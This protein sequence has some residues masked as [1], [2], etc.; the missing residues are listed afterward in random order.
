MMHAPLPHVDDVWL[1]MHDHALALTQHQY[2]QAALQATRAIRDADAKHYQRLAAE[3]GHAYTHEGLTSIWKKIKAVLPKNRMKQRSAKFDIECELQQHFA[4]LEAGTEMPFEE[5][6]RQCILRN[7]RDQDACLTPSFIDLHELPTLAE[8]EDLCLKQRPLRAAGLDGIPPEVCRQAAVAIAPFLHNV[9]LKAFLD[10][11]E[12]FSYKGGL[13]CPIWKQKLPRHDASGYRGILLANVFGKVLHAWARSRLLPTLLARSAAGQIGGLPSQQTSTA[14]QLLR[15]HGKLGRARKLSTAALFVD[16]RAA[17]HHMLREFIF[18]VR[19]PATR[20]LL[21]RI[22]DANEFD[23]EQLSHDL[24]AECDRNPADIPV[25]LRAF[26]HDIHK[27]TWY[28]LDARSKTATATTR[29]TRPGSP[30]ADIGFN[31]LITKILHEVEEALQKIPDYVQ[32]CQALGVTIPPLAWVDDLAIPVAVLRPEAL[33]PVIQEITGILHSTFRSHGLTMNLE[34]GKTEAVLMYR[35]SGAP[36]HRA[37]LFA[38]ETPPVIVI[39]TETHISTL[40]VVAAYRHLGSQYTMN[41]DIEHEIL[42]RIA[43]ARQAFEELKRP[44]FLN[45]HIPI[46]GRLQ[47]YNSLI[48]SRLLYGCAVWSDIPAAQVRKL[49]AF[50]IDH[51]RRIA[52][53]GF[54]NGATM[55]DEDLRHHLE[56]PTFRVV[57]ARHRLIYLQHIARHGKDFH[58]QLLLLEFQLRR[59]WLWEALADLCW[60]RSLIDLPFAFEDDTIDWHAVWNAIAHCP[61]WKAMVQRA[62]RKHV[63]QERIARDVKHFHNLI[64]HEMRDNDAPIDESVIDEESPQAQ[65]LPCRECDRVFP[66]LQALGAHEYQKHGLTSLERPYIQSTVCPG[67]LKDFWTTWRVQQ[68]LRYRNNKCWDRIHG[69][70]QP[71]EPVTIG[72]PQHLRHVKR[73]P[74]VRRHHGPLLPTGDQRRRRQL[75]L[76]IDEL[77]AQGQD[78]FAWWHPEQDPH[79]AQ[80]ACATFNAVLVAWCALPDPDAIQFQNMFF[81]AIFSLEIPEL[82]GGRL[83]VHWIETEF[84]DQ[85]PQDL[86]PDAARCLEEAHMQMLDDIPAWTMRLQMKHLLSVWMHQMS[87]EEPVPTPSPL[88]TRPYQRRHFIASQYSAMGAEEQQ[89]GQ[90]KILQRFPLR[91]PS[92][93][94]PYYVVHLYS[95]RRRPQDFH[96]MVEELITNLLGRTVRI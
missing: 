88:T 49:E 70:R 81:G 15:L 37:A 94:G 73:L 11:T 2:R 62:C 95:G 67:C 46:E 25:A 19:E 31:L 54:W 38:R 23:I 83:F 44:I 27:N 10:G 52:D 41:A 55:T 43:T 21:Y 80:R 45:R 93:F 4:D 59:G 71:D 20:S 32:G 22:F 48:I 82:L 50:F 29:G 30:L 75:Q 91:E 17:F 33:I 96:A 86:D 36:A 16:L 18:A 89:R 64:V 53:I 66:T 65:H 78:E 68:H 35:G 85:W 92:D 8:I 58:Q 61:R 79:L 60:M 6:E 42:T 56:I 1:K 7:Q 24:A 40:K 74:A 51:H 3:A 9:I 63:Q 12:P 39:A 90:W 28:K 72:L 34:K 84:Y 13:L 77:K 76:R 47:L 5:A 14:I 87:E 26:L 57:W 69:I